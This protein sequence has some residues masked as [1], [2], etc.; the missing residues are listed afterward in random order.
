MLFYYLQTFCLHDWCN[1]QI[2][3]KKKGSSVVVAAAV[4]V[5]EV[6]VVIFCIIFKSLL[7]ILCNGGFRESS[8]G[9]KKNEAN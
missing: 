6:V 2:W 7:R 1:L 4:V 9:Q 8:K 3:K 5:A